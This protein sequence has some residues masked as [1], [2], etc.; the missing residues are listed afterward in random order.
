[1]CERRA[2]G[3]VQHAARGVAGQEMQNVVRASTT[4]G[5]GHYEAPGALYPPATSYIV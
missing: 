5:S 1:M 4:R 2:V 3:P